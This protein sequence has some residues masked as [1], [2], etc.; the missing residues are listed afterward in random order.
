MHDLWGTENKCDVKRCSSRYKALERRLRYLFPPFS[1]VSLRRC[2]PL[3][4]WPQSR[5]SV[6]ALIDGQTHS[7]NRVSARLV[8]RYLLKGSGGLPVGDK[9]KKKQ[10][11]KRVGVQKLRSSGS[12]QRNGKQATA[13]AAVAM[14]AGNRRQTRRS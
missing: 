11:P 13:A 4:T 6:H 10:P 1:F 3:A 2:P 12:L 5:Y 14:T 9:K 7:A 8:G